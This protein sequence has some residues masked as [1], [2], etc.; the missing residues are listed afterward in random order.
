MEFFLSQISGL[1]AD[2]EEPSMSLSGSPPPASHMTSAEK[3][4]DTMSSVVHV[5]TTSSAAAVCSTNTVQSPPA[6]ARLVCFV[7]LSFLAI[8][9]DDY[10]NL[11][12]LYGVY[13]MWTVFTGLFSMFV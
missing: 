10:Q 8:E 7:R 5:A 9:R 11:S 13:T 3:T 6:V 4:K 1:A 12:V 2:P